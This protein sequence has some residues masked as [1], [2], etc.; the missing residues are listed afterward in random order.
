LTSARQPLDDDSVFG[1]ARN[2]N[3]YDFVRK[4]TGSVGRACAAM[5]FKREAILFFTR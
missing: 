3:R 5:A 1:F 4:M 2:L